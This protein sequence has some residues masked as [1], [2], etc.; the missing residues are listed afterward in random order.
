MRISTKALFDLTSKT[1]DKNIKDILE[2]V[3]SDKSE[4]SKSDLS[5]SSN[6]TDVKM[7]INNLLKELSNSTKTKENIVQEIKQSDIPKLMKNTT[8]ELKTLLSLIKSDKTLFKFAPTLEKLLLDVKEIK[9]ETLKQDLA[10]SGTLME[11]KLTSSKT[12]MMPTSLKE[13]LKSLK[14]ELVK[15]NTKE[16]SSVKSLDTLLNSKKI[17]KSSVPAL[18][19]FVKE[20]KKEP[21]LLKQITPLIKKLDTLVKQK[22]PSKQSSIK[23]VLVDI[24]QVIDKASKQKN[25]LHVKTIDKILDTPKADKGFVDDIKTLILNIKQS[26]NIAKPTVQV[27]AKL[28]EL[29]Q[30]S[31]LVNSKIK[32][33]LQVTPKETSTVITQIKE[34]LSQLK[35][36]VGKKDPILDTKA[37]EITKLVEQTLKTPDFFPKELSKAT[38]S[39]KLQQVV[40]I[41]KS[42]LVKSDVKNFSNIEITKLTNR[43][44]SVIKEQIHTKQIVPNQKLQVEVPIKQELANDIKSTLLSIKHELSTQATTGA[45]DISLH[46]DKLI[47]QVEY[48]QLVSLGTNSQSTYLPFLWD[49]LEEGQ[50]SLKKLKENRFFC[51]INLKLKEYGKIDLMLM[52]F[53]DIYLNISVFAEKEEFIDLVQEN[54]LSLKQGINKLGLIPSNVQLKKAELKEETKNPTDLLG[55]GLNIE[56]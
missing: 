19:D 47:T 49:G 28:E 51:E 37:Q 39:E 26:K 27:V 25:T 29:V 16:S 48:F 15:A 53:D 9:P 3:V 7:L 52:L 45:R 8:S 34:T 42:E 20:L 54:L 40:N 56:V 11:S 22:T 31:E 24:K 36:L 38:V 23:E 46:V 1:D 32:N 10:K 21:D 12:E 18:Q 13:V 17:D 14:E 41:I 55:T 30:K 2:K 44:E 5:Q 33:N 35:E 50:V 4:L 6:K 43:L